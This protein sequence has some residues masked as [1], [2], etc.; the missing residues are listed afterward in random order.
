MGM[1]CVFRRASDDDLYLLLRHPE[2]IISY[3]H[4]DEELDAPPPAREPGFLARLFGRKVAPPPPP[5]PP[6]PAPPARD[7]REEDDETSV[8]KAWHGLHYLFTGTAWESAGPAGYLLS[9]GEPIGDVDVGYGAARAIHSP[10]VQRFADFLASFDREELLRRYDPSRMKELDIYP[11]IWDDEG[12]GGAFDYLWEYFQVLCDFV[13]EAARR[14]S[15]MI[16]Y[17]G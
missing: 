3:L 17:L 12:E 6:L 8:D 4:G 11:K 7:A 14:R 10:G 13:A 5:P 9:G 15:G 16:I 2:W 1:V